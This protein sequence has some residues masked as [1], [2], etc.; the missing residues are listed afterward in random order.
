MDPIEFISLA[1]KLSSSHIQAE[2]HTSVSRAYYGAF[3]TARELLE[4]C[5]IRFPPKELFGADI[6]R[7]I[8]FCLANSANADGL[9][10]AGTLQVLRQQRNFADYDLKNDRFSFPNARNVRICM[11][12][13]IE[14]VDALQRCQSEASISPFRETVRGYA[15]DVLRLPVVEGP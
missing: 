14:I 2:L 13:A 12:R 10:A 7:K 1:V 15:R 9:L 8:R 5:G 11:Q 4:A 3:H 6:H